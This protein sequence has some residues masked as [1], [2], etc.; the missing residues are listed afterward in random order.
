VS[1]EAWKST[2]QGAKSLC[3]QRDLGLS[4]ISALSKLCDLGQGT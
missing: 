3:F 1:S 4:L 2:G